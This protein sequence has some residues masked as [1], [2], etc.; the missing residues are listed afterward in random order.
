MIS[1]G[2]PY[3]PARTN[4]MLSSVNLLVQAWVASC[5]GYKTE[6]QQ[7][8][9]RPLHCTEYSPV[10]MSK[11]WKFIS[12]SNLSETI[13][14]CHSPETEGE[15]LWP[16]AIWYSA[17]TQK[18]WSSAHKQKCGNLHTVKSVDICTQTNLKSNVESNSKLLLNHSYCGTH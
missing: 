3:L 16:S 6:Q 8:L 18:V 14:Q 2:H 5:A 11:L 17:H 13:Y 1:W 15:K 9:A 10:T 12:L 4:L 7:H